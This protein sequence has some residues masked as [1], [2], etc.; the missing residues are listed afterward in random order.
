MRT[1]VY[2]SLPMGNLSTKVGTFGRTHSFKFL[3]PKLGSDLSNPRTIAD[4]LFV[5]AHSVTGV[6]DAS[7]HDDRKLYCG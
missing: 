4:A 3:I 2:V 1:T 7:R 6:A 5:D